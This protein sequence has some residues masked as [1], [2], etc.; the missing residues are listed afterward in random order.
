MRRKNIKRILLFL[1]IFISQVADV[2]AVENN[3]LPDLECGRKG[4]LT[5]SCRVQNKDKTERPITGITISIYQVAALNVEKGVAIYKMFDDYAS[6]NII[7]DN[8][9]A[10]ESKRA[11]VIFSKMQEEKKIYGQN[12]TTNAQGEGKY[13]DLEPGMYLVKQTGIIKQYKEMSP[14]LISVPILDYDGTWR[15]DIVAQPKIGI[16]KKDTIKKPEKPEAS[17]DEEISSNSVHSNPKTGDDMN[18]MFWVSM[19]GIAM[20]GILCIGCKDCLRR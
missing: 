15:Y 18:L 6:A 13:F 20:L 5:V 11:A 14:F 2:R 1:I 4:S 7:F 19:L 9:A 3:N 17:S 12:V 16:T 8:M 10:S